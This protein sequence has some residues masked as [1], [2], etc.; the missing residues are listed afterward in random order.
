MFSKF[1]IL[2]FVMYNAVDKFL[3]ITSTI[4]YSYEFLKVYFI[5]Y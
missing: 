5:L 2:F 3:N 1:A 4:N